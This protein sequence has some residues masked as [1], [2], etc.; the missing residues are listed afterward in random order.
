MTG[1]GRLTGAGLRRGNGVQGT[2]MNPPPSLPLLWSHAVNAAVQPAVNN[3]RT[4]GRLAVAVGSVPA[5]TS[6]AR[7]ATSANSKPLSGACQSWVAY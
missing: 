2:A 1:N 4:V 5:M 6:P 3:E 7:P